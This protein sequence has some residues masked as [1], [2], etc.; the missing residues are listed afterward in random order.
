[1]VHFRTVDILNVRV[2]CLDFAG[3]LN[4]VQDWLTG[5]ERRTILY[6]NAHSLNC[7][8][9]DPRLWSALNQA[10]LVYADG[11]SVVWAS[12]F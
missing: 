9:E 6:A 3:I 4:Q 7:A 10:D 12:R 1:M 5:K 2:A 11:V 8:C